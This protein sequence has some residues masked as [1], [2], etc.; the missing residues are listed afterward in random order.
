MGILSRDTVMKS[1]LKCQHSFFIVIKIYNRL[2]KDDEKDFLADL[3][4]K[5]LVYVNDKTIKQ[6]CLSIL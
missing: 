2:E 6:K 5:N 3:I 4:S 1:M